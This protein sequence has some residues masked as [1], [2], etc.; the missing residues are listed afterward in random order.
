MAGARTTTPERIES[1]LVL[2]LK[3][4]SGDPEH[5]YF[6]DGMTDA[7][8]ARLSGV[9]ALAGDLSN[10]VDRFIRERISRFRK[11]RAS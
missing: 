7:L 1:L 10:F 9:S 6:A 4:L 8:N 3:S 2:P 11:S 5:D